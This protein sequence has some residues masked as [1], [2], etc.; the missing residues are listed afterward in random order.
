M[1]K[2]YFGKAAVLGA[3]VSG[4]SAIRLLEDY[5]NR[6][7]VFDD[8]T[9]KTP[10]EVNGYPVRG[11][12]KGRTFYRFDIAVPSPGIPRKVLEKIRAPLISEVELG[13]RKLVREA[14]FI[15]SITGTNGKTTV[16]T[17]LNHLLR[18]ENPVMAGNVGIPLSSV[19]VDRG[20]FVLELSSFQ[21][22]INRG[23]RFDIAILLNVAP[24]HLDW[25]GDFQHYLQSKLRMFAYMNEKDVA[26]LNMDDEIVVDSTRDIR[27]RKLYFS[28]DNPSA[29]AYWVSDTLFVMGEEVF[30]LGVF[31]HASRRMF[32]MVHNRYNLS[33]TALAIYDYFYRSGREP[34]EET[35]R[36]LS[37]YLPSYQFPPHRLQFVAEIG[38]IEFYNDSKATNPHAV[39]HALRTFEKCV[40]IMAGLTKGLDLTVLKD[41]IEKRVTHLIGIGVICEDLKRD[42]FEPVCVNSLEEAVEKALELSEGEPVL[43]SPGGSSF[44]MFRNYAHRGEEFVKVVERIA[45]K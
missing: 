30:H 17:L 12:V 40:L 38:G 11:A 37:A 44:D 32:S 6:I 2:L 36:V 20:V 41:E 1:N 18:E 28:L 24:D 19:K 16:T 7:E 8:R 45:N 39:L 4:R 10:A 27:P 43:F 42:G 34:A 21:L 26:I 31:S 5:G 3:G 22:S 29:D 14:S 35:T 23:M 25:H 33:A 9:F 15:F 13:Y